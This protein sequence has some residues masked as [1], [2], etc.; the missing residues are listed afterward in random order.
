MKD[1]P[2][3]GLSLHKQEYKFR[4]LGL[5]KCV[6]LCFMVPWVPAGI[7]KRSVSWQHSVKAVQNLSRLQTWMQAYQ[8][9]LPVD[10]R[11]SPV[12]LVNEQHP[13]Q[14]LGEHLAGLAAALVDVAGH[15]VGGRAAHHLAATQQAE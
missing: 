8:Q 10:R 2:T 13:A 4:G 15:K 3:L 6:N 7:A 9:A 11:Y 5:N 1:P 14:R 12:R